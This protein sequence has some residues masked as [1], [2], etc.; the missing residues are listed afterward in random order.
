M[1]PCMTAQRFMA[2][3]D[4]PP[5]PVTPAAVS[6]GCMG[7]A[8]C[9]PRWGE[10]G[11]GLHQYPPTCAWHIIS[12]MMCQDCPQHTSTSPMATGSLC[13]SNTVTLMTEGRWGA[14]ARW[15]TTPT[16]SNPESTMGTVC[17]KRP[18]VQSWNPGFLRWS[19]R[20]HP[21]QQLPRSGSPAVWV[22]VPL[23]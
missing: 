6:G 1:N 7:P 19:R 21:P 18:P 15:P 20:T 22:R 3:A 4:V 12:G 5:R 23:K 8:T 16:D 11:G 10:H 14:G 13:A 17:P 2:V 9:M